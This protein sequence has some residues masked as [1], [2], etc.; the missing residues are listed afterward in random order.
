MSATPLFIQQA[1]IDGITQSIKSAPIIA[2]FPN[3][4][5]ETPEDEYEHFCD[6]PADSLTLL[7][8]KATALMIYPRFHEAVETAEIFD[9]TD[10]AAFAPVVPRCTVI[11]ESRNLS[12]SLRIR[13]IV[14]SLETDRYSLELVS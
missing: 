14:F 5:R 10:V 8:E 11:D 12:A 7:Q 13:A 1:T 3:D 2:L 4:R 9:F 6:N